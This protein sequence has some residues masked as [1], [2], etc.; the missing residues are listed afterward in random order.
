MTP[1]S[2]AQDSLSLL[3][4]N[5]L[6]TT[7][8]LPAFA[9]VYLLDIL[10]PFHDHIPFLFA[11]LAGDL[12]SFLFLAPLAVLFYG[13]LLPEPR[14]KSGSSSFLGRALLLLCAMFAI[15]VI[16]WLGDGLLSVLVPYP[17]DMAD[18]AAFERYDT[19]MRTSQYVL[20]ALCCLCLARVALLFPALAQ[21][22]RQPLVRAW[23]LGRGR[24][25]R[26]FFGLG[27]LAVPLTVISYLL[28]DLYWE[29]LFLWAEY[30]YRTSEETFFFRMN[31][32]DALVSALLFMLLAA[33]LCSA[34]RTLT[35]S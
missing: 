30:V 11:G 15:K 27:I 7:L 17:D 20:Q 18:D 25:F 3:W 5:W 8:F 2:L 10:I 32:A 35:D 28:F 13:R 31:V 19:I 14:T 24:T 22:V 12:F 29:R 6:M 1:F 26:V 23:E 21:G 9:A 16:F 4:R 34:Y 33:G